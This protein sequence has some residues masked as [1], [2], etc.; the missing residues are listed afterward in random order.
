MDFGAGLPASGEIV[1]ASFMPW[2][3]ADS[4]TTPGTP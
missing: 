2:A 4:I 1:A 3:I